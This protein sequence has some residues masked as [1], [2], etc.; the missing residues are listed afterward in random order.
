A[1]G[2]RVTLLVRPRIKAEIRGHGLS[3]T[4]FG[5]MAVQVEPEDI[6]L[7]QEAEVLG[8]ADVILVTVK[9]QNTEEMAYLIGKHARPGCPVV[10]LQNG[11]ANARLL[12]TALPGYDVRASMVPFNVVPMG[13]GGFHRATS[14]DLVIEAGE[15]DLADLLSVPNLS[16]MESRDIEAIQW[17]KFLINLNNALNALS[18]LTVQAQL[19]NRAWRRLM[20]DQWKEALGVLR[21]H[22]IAPASTTPVSVATVPFIL[23]LPTPLFMR[24]AA[25]MLTIDPQA[26]TSMSLDLMGGRKTEIEDLQGEV[27]RM[28]REKGIPTPICA[29]VADLIETAEAAGEGLPHLPVRAIRAEL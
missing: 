26:R 11:L 17:G 13:Q 7:T 29:L 15:G 14:G 20:A 1:G 18:G 6:A 22:G 9:S 3:L 10:S 5:G 27:V 2:R 28:G 8:R 19:R 21:A 24:V 4:D 12:R 25:A 23:K 16:V